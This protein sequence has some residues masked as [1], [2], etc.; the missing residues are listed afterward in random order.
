MSIN[1]LKQKLDE[2]SYELRAQSSEISKKQDLIDLLRSIPEEPP[3][4]LELIIK[5]VNGTQKSIFGGRSSS[6]RQEAR[7]ILQAAM[8]SAYAEIREKLIEKV[9]KP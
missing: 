9:T 8:K 7:E 5:E 4:N 2:M 1:N 3:E 6:I